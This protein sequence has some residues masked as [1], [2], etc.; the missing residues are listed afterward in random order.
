[1]IANRYQVEET[2]GQGGMAAVY[3]VFDTNTNQE[4]ALKQLLTKESSEKHEDISKLFE[5]EFHILTQLAHP[6]VIEVYDYGIDEAGPY[7]TME[8]LDGGDLREL[9]PMPWKKACSLMSDICSALGLLHSRR[10]LHRDLTPRNIRCTRDGKAK[11]IDFGALAPMGPC[12]YVIGTPPLTSP[13]VVSLQSLD[14]RT[15]LYSLGTTF[16]YALTGHHAYPAKSFSELREL[17][18]SK[19]SPPSSYVEDIPEEL[20]N[21]VLSLISYDPMGRPIN[22]A[23]V[24][25]RLCAIAGLVLN[26]QLLTSQ[27]YLST[28]TL[29]GRER[30]LSRVRKR[31]VRALFHRGSTIVVE[32]GSGVGRS[33]FLNACVLEGKLAGAIVLKADASDA[34]TGAWGTI[35]AIGLRLLDAVPGL[36][37]EKAEPYLSVL[38][39]ILPELLIKAEARRSSS[40]ESSNTEHIDSP[41]DKRGFEFNPWVEVWGGSYSSQPPPPDPGGQF[42]LQSFSGSQELRSRVQSAL[43]DWLQQVSEQQCLMVAVDD[44]HRIDEPSAASIALLS[45]EITQKMLVVVVTAE[46][47]APAI[48]LAAVK[49]LKDTSERINLINLSSEQTERLLGSIFGETRNVRIFS[50]KL[51]TISLGNPRAIMQFTQHLLDKGLIR[52]RT[53]TWTLP[54]SIDIGDLPGSLSEA[55]RTRAHK[56]SD[57]ALMLAQTMALS[58]QQSFTY[59]ECLLLTEHQ[60]KDRL[61][62]NLDELIASEVLSTEGEYYSLS[63]HIWVSVL[64]EELDKDKKRSLHLKLAE[65]FGKRGGEHFREAQHLLIAGEEALA[66]DV[67]VRYIGV[68]RQRIAQSPGAF[69][70]YIQ[71]LP[72]SWVA[73]F[74]TLIQKGR[75]LGRPKR[76]IYWLQSALVT[77]QAATGSVNKAHLIEV[78]EQLTHDSGLSCYQTLN[79]S[80]DASARLWQAIEMAQQRYDSSGESERV[81]DPSTAIGELVQVIIAAINL[82]GNSL[83]FLL[84]SSLPSLEPLLPLSPA[85]DIVDKDI[86]TTSHL[87]A[88]RY[89]KARQ[90]YLEMLGRVIQPDHAG[91]DES[92][93]DYTHL[94][95]IYAVGMIEASLGLKWKPKWIDELEAYPLYHVNAWRIRMVYCLRQGDALSA[96]KCKSR[97]EILQIQN[98]PAQVFEGTHLLAEITVFSSCNDLMGVRQTLDEIRAMADRFEAWAPVLNFARGEYQRIRGDYPRALVE[99]EKALRLTAPGYHII[100]TYIAGVYLN[101]LFHLGRLQEVKELGR[102]FLEAA[103]RENLGIAG[104]LI[105]V[106]VAPALAKLGETEQAVRLVEK[107]ID[108]VEAAGI[109]GVNLGVA[110]ETR[111]RVAIFMNDDECFSKYAERCAEQYKSGHNYALTARYEKLIQE[112]RQAE[113]IVSSELAQAAEFSQESARSVI[114]TVASML[115]ECKGPDERAERA[116][117]LLV[118]KSDC[119]GG[120]LFTIQKE[121]PVLSAQSGNYPPPP[122]MDTMVKSYILSEVED[123]DDSM[124]RSSSIDSA[125]EKTVRWTE[126]KKE[127]YRP[128]VLGHNTP[129][130]FGITGLAVLVLSRDRV[131]NFPGDALTAVS[132]F[133]IDA[134]DTSLVLRSN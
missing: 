47:D 130:G 85:I 61:I 114:S 107:V 64:V 59:Q 5:H 19:P 70:E 33:R 10:R 105:S 27:S 84:L 53:G 31:V 8:L 1:M 121:G 45:H 80:I 65:I 88:G 67:L 72:D 24:M 93:Y 82:A 6:R 48:S 66:F 129:R 95:L 38:G 18:R 44:I 96:E 14:A 46:T 41:L 87:I 22:A 58:P 32:G 50:D 17:W 118:E 35:R 28:P 23:E 86:R 98:S 106:A 92:S 120:F 128:L 68:F 103:E 111:A 51:Y 34:Y 13:E 89:E 123:S 25:E 15:D 73:T 104:T 101:T 109:T 119:A 60:D 91:L 49:L 52:Y 55:I 99:F 134:G 77:L 2:L 63:Q 57:D 20:D 30:Q 127:R 79:S 132:K 21:L 100:W 54:S 9:A 102:K 3:R 56:L 7:Y 43:R 78:I 39:H 83:D 36:A 4:V 69:F 117:Q 81:L 124:H 42:K 97:I 126:Q 113:L 12:K 133:L 110:Y 116:L 75:T 62:Q 112:A 108:E 94:N 90:G 131:F 16:Y 74:E 26:D 37:L 29:I 122:D 71:S 11:L 125:L 40:V 115:E 76:E